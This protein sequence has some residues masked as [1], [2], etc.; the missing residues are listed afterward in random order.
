MGTVG[1]VDDPIA[2]AQTA[3][4]T[5][6]HAEQELNDETIRDVLLMNALRLLNLLRSEVR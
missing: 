4:L 3:L 1:T 2:Q 6:Q 5:K